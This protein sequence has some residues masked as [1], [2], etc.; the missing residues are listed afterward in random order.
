VKRAEKPT[1]AH[2]TRRATK[3]RAATP[4]ELDSLINSLDVHFVGLTECLVSEGNRLEMA[5]SAAVGIH[6]NLF[7]SGTM[8]VEGGASIDL[9]PH[10]LIIVPPHHAFQ[11]K[12]A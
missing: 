3:P 2:V 8:T 11:L 10:M 7:G 12:V 1:S 4:P 9:T 5:T 6:Y